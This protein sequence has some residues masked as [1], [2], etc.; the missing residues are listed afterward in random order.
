MCLY[1]GPRLII[2]TVFP[3]M[4]IS[5]LKIRR[6]RDRLIFNMGIP[7]LVRRH[8][9]IETAPRFHQWQIGS[10][11]SDQSVQVNDHI[12]FITMPSSGESYLTDRCQGHLGV[13]VTWS[14]MATLSN[15]YGRQT[16]GNNTKGVNHIEILNGHQPCSCRY[17]VIGVSR[18]SAAAAFTHHTA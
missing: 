8:L 13:K 16:D 2:K 1:P 10:H 3:S 18:A 9:Y 15:T 6:S 17:P 14:H 7:I 12:W 11:V 5:M 4:R